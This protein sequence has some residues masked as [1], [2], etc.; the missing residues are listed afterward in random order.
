MTDLLENLIA[1]ANFEKKTAKPRCT[2]LQT[3]YTSNII[4]Y[5]WSGY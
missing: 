4:H 2:W 5:I 3:D 1:L